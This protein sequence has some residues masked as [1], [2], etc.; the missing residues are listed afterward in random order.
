M[1]SA[2]HYEKIS[3]VF[4]KSEKRIYFFNL[5]NK[6][7]TASVYIAYPMLLLYVFLFCRDKLLKSVLVPA[8]MLVFVSVLRKIINRPRPYEKM[9]IN[10]IIKKDKSGE[11]MP[12]RHIF[13]AFMIAMTFLYISPIF[14]IPLFVIAVVLAAV[15]VIGGVHYISDVIV[16][17]AIGLT[18]G[19]LAYFV[20]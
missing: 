13:S 2:K 7:L 20:F 3:A 1:V 10:P 17:A 8:A 11:S 4:F 5:F 9:E 12:S 15:R 18:A 16:A 14:S 6:L 19:T